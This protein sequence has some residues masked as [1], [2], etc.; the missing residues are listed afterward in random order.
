MN[1]FFLFFIALVAIDY[2][3][4]LFGLSDDVSKMLC[5]TSCFVSSKLY[6]VPSDVK[7]PKLMNQQSSTNFA[8]FLGWSFGMRGKCSLCS[9]YF[10]N[11][12]F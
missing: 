10:D 9:D 2:G 6:N 11:K 4:S 12:H 8:L 5:T 7:Q 1:Y 3:L